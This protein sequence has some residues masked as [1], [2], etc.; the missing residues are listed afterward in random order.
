MIDTSVITRNISPID[1]GK[2][3]GLQPNRAG[4]CRCPLHGE[5]TGSMKLYKEPERG[6]YCFGCHQGGD[7]IR[8]VRVCLN[9]DFKAAVEW[10]DV[11]YSLGLADQKSPSER[12]EMRKKADQRRMA[13]RKLVEAL[14]IADDLKVTV[15]AMAVRCMRLADETAPKRADEA[16]DPR[17]AE[18]LSALSE[19]RE[20]SDRLAW[21]I[22]QMESETV[23]AEDAIRTA[24]EI[25]NRLAFRYYGELFGNVT[26]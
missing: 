1:V 12:E 11:E 15:D 14:G 22:D 16:W 10:F 23:R 9:C 6:W 2:R 5:K 25:R 24:E 19:C 13:R 26:A 4:F 18:A 20:M 21:A 17:Y 8:L 3:L 7:V